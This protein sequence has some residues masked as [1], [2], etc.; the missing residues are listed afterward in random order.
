MRIGKAQRISQSRCMVTRSPDEILASAIE[1][2]RNVKFGRGVVS[3]TSYVAAF[4]V[5]VWFAIVWKWSD[6]LV[7]DGGL[8][9][10]GLIVS[11]FAFWYIRASQSF[12][13]RNPG[14]ALLDGA[15]FLEWTRIEAAAKGVRPSGNQP[16]LEVSP[17]P[18][19]GG[20]NA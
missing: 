10:I 19:L 20:P 1:S 6:N 15:E 9:A 16:Q 17:M 2:S 5:A 3:K 7:A 11:A 14:Q 13:E 4:V 18:T 12:A 8:L